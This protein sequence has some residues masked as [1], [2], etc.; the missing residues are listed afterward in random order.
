LRIQK[1]NFPNKFNYKPAPVTIGT[2]KTNP[3]INS[4]LIPDAEEWEKGLIFLVRYFFV[5]EISEISSE[6]MQKFT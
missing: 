1:Q 6:K 3:S 4:K 5:T 2:E